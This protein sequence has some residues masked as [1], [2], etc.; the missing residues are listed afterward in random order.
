MLV[1]SK[2]IQAIFS[3]QITFV[4]SGIKLLTPALIATKDLPSIYTGYITEPSPLKTIGQ[5]MED[6]IT[7]M[8][9]NPKVVVEFRNIIRAFDKSGKSLVNI[10]K[11]L[12][13]L[14]IKVIDDFA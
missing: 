10:D 11:S 12:R 6:M 13:N 5:L 9:S 3:N 7:S 8:R 1:V 14:G 2:A 4:T